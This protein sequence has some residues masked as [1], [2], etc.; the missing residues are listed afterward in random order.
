MM[1]KLAVIIPYRDRAE[2][3][4]EFLRIFPSK[5]NVDK[6]SQFC[7]PYHIFAIEQANHK[8]FNR[9]KL[10]NVGFTLTQ[11]DFDYFCFHDVDMMPDKADYSY[12]SIPTHLA[13]NVSQFRHWVGKGLAYPTY[14]GGVVLFNKQDFLKVNGYSNSYWGYGAE[15]DD[16]LCRILRNGL[17]WQ[18]REGK[19]ESLFH[20]SNARTVHHQNNNNRLLRILA[21]QEI[22]ASGLTNLDFSIKDQK[23]YSTYTFY[24]VDI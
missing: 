1:E 19:F 20:P 18:R 24:S 6:E 14:F 17:M 7:I 3:L 15:D 11:T 4:K 2:H 9:A 23:K 5:I 16:L 22:D 10:L 12:P 8:P 13:T 21:G